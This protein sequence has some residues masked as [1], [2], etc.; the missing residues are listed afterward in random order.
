MILYG[1]DGRTRGVLELSGPYRADEVR[2]T[3][4]VDS[5]AGH[6]RSMG[7]RQGRGVT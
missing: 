2:Q 5:A 4:D 3:Q 7:I 1:A 6:E